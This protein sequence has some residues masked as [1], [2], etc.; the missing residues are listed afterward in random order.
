MSY[1][2]DPVGGEADQYSGHVMT[3]PDRVVWLRESALRYPH[4]RAFVET[5]TA[6]GETCRGVSD[7]FDRNATIDLDAARSNYIRHW[8]K[9]F[10]IDIHVGDSAKVLPGIVASFNQP[11]MYWL[12]AHFCGGVRGDVDTP[13]LAELAA[14]FAGGHANLIHVD[15]ARLFGVDPAY[16]TVEELEVLA[17][18]AGYD[19]KVAA[20]VITLYH[21]DLPEPQA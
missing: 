21:R 3:G 10:P 18:N 17:A 4:L 20:G 19:L 6:D 15:D 7:L 2:P 13:V 5:G 12:D 11:T 14:I 1:A 9:H 8:F 16:P